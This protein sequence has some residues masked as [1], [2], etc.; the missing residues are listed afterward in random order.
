MKEL[1]EQLKRCE[2]WLEENA[3]DD[4]V[5]EKANEL[6]TEIAR[7][8]NDANKE[9]LLKQ[10]KKKEKEIKEMKKD[11]V[12]SVPIIKGFEDECYALAHISS[13]INNSIIKNLN[14]RINEYNDLVLK[15]REVSK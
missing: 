3:D 12:H 6:R 14:E 15:Y 10:L 11:I 2:L 13:E 7:L 4:E 1:K 8:Q 5:I 9:S